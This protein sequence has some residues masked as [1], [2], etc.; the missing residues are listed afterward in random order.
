MTEYAAG[1]LQ[2]FTPS[3]SVVPGI[4]TISPYV[5]ASSLNQSS[6]LEGS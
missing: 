6:C 4:M 5:R 2:A 3:G 1:R